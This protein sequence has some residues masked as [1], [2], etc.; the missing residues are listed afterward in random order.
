MFT[1]FFVSLLTGAALL[2]LLSTLP[3]RAA[4]FTAATADELIAAVAAANGNTEADTINLVGNPAISLTAPL[5]ITADLT[6]VGPGTLTGAGFPTLLYIA[7]S[8]VTLDT[9]TFLECTT[10]ISAVMAYQATLTI[11]GCAFTDCNATT[12][13]P[14]I[15]GGALFGF[16]TNVTLTDSTFTGNTTT[17]GAGA[18]GM[19]YGSLTA[20]GCTFTDNASPGAE[21]VWSGYA[22]A[23]AATNC[24]LQL[25]DSTFTGNTSVGMG[26]AVGAWYGKVSLSG[27]TFTENSATY[28]GGA[29]FASAP[30]MTA[31]ACTFTGNRSLLG[32][33]IGY[34]AEADEE[35]ADYLM[36]LTG[37]VFHDNSVEG[38]FLPDTN[39]AITGGGAIVTIGDA[40]AI[41]CRFT[42]NRAHIVLATDEIAV[43]AVGGAVLS[44]SGLF[45]ALNCGFSANSVTSVNTSSFGG[46][47]AIGG[48]IGTFADG[49]YQVYA[50]NC[51]F[52]GNTAN[53]S[54]TAPEMASAFGGGI[55]L[56]G[57]VTLRNS[58]LWGNLA[59]GT[60]DQAEYV[61]GD[62]PYR[63]V[64]YCDI[65]GGGW[66]GTGNI[67][68]DPAFVRNP[69]AGEDGIWGTADDD[70]GDLALRAGSPC[71]DAGSNYYVYPEYMA[72][73]LA[74]NPRIVNEI[75]DMGAYEY[76]GGSVQD[77]ILDL[78]QAVQA[79]I[80]A[81]VQ[82]PADGKS[83]Q[84]KLQ[85]A[86]DCLTAGDLDGARGAIGAFINQ[87]QAF[88]QVGKL[89]Q[90]QADALL[91]AAN[92]ILA[93]LE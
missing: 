40:V 71:I 36:W 11:T 92:A 58:I 2:L 62:W 3:A 24:P 48:A 65:Q 46:A 37:C 20:S 77:A 4:D 47:R 31:D 88:L 39:Q 1:R 82:L 6:V 17:A 61:V 23:I 52:S 53:A 67:D 79:L 89:T 7:N 9:L 87:V 76:Q 43:D 15:I 50:G 56:A 81:G 60:P 19:Q 75:V 70:A 57:P 13:W 72:T 69:G 42:N 91:A 45:G 21:S 63:Y 22:G 51:T 93:M 8:T 25:T 44:I 35:E 26:G 85:Y 16:E 64:D 86:L 78:Q 14:D 59:N 32:G 30:G 80:D 27:C 28:V 68:A 41:N 74:G 10:E 33:A 90:A 29:V 18:V 12:P 83:L 66:A 73:D 34:S 54:A 84:V 49:Y 5:E 38:E 55:A